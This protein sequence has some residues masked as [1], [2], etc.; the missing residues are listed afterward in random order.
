MIENNKFYS[1]I[2]ETTNKY[3]CC[4]LSNEELLFYFPPISQLAISC[5]L[6]N[7]ELL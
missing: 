7:E 4:T 6:S 2:K 5:T 1:K 3:S